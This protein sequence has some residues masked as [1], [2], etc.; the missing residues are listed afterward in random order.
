MTTNIEVRVGLKKGM[1]DPEGANVKKALKLLGFEN[2]DAVES[3]KFYKIAI[4]MDE[5][6]ALKEAEKMCQRLL[7]NPVVHEYSITVAK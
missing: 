5:K 2:V 1:A 3:V 4:D 7:A 6:N